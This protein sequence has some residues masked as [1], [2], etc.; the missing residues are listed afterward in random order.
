MNKTLAEIIQSIVDRK[1]TYSELNVL[2][3]TSKTS[4]WRLIVESIAFV[5]WNFQNLAKLHLTEIE[6]KIK[7]QKVP[8][9]RWYRNQALRFQYGFDLN[10]DSFTGEFLPYYINNGSQILATE[11]EIEDSKIIK[12]ASVTRNITN[13]GVRISMKIAGEDIDGVIGAPEAEAF[14]TYVQEIQAAGDHITIVNYL[15]DRLFINIKI[16]YNPL[17]L[18]DTGQHI[19][20]GKYPVKE[21][22]LS[23]LKNLPFN[24]ELSIQKLEEAILAVDGVDDLQNL[25]ILSK[26]IEPGVGYGQ[27]QPITISKIPKS[28][29]FT[30]KDEMGNEDW[31]GITYTNYT[32]AT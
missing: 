10:P 6:Q 18:L 16:C 28:G 9:E 22:I 4:I 13:N 21:A 17:L 19:I 2:N 24:G 3:S 20:T 1:N 14:K 7:E 29:R 32:P 5:I 27:F 25:Q 26:W 12:Y 31:S 15:P 8:N 11:Q 30:I 23:F